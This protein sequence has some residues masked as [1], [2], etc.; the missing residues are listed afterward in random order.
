VSTSLPLPA[1]PARDRADSASFVSLRHPAYRAYCGTAMA[2]MLGDNLAS[3]TRGSMPSCPGPE[4]PL[5]Y[6]A[7]PPIQRLAA[8]LSGRPTRGLR[9]VPLAVCRAPRSR[10]AGPPGRAGSGTGA[11]GLAVCRA[12]GRGRAGNPPLRDYEA[13]AAHLAPRLI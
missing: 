9:P 12:T 3:L 2:S 4:R 10:Y 1:P 13:L 8:R 5:Q 11:V 6:A 7:S